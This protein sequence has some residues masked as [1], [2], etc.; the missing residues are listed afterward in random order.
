MQVFIWDM[1][2]NIIGELQQGDGR[3]RQNKTWKFKPTDDG[4]F[5]RHAKQIRGEIANVDKKDAADREFLERM[6]CIRSGRPS[7][8]EATSSSAAFSSSSSASSTSSSSS[9]L[10]SS[11]SSS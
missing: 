6:E 10:S 11:S 4:T 9:S 3:E 8:G 1:E 5:T 2:G 7:G